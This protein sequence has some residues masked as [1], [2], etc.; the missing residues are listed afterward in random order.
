ML[1][2]MEHSEHSIVSNLPL[3]LQESAVQ[4]QLLYISTP[5][6]MTGFNLVLAIQPSLRLVASGGGDGVIHIWDTET[7]HS[8][9]LEGQRG[10]VT[11]LAFSSD[12]Y[13]LLSGT[14]EDTLRIWNV[15]TRSYT[16]TTWDECLFEANFSPDDHTVALACSDGSV[17]IW[18][19]A[20]RTWHSISR[21]PPRN[22]L[23]SIIS[24]IA[25]SADGKFIASGAWS[26]RVCIWDVEN[27]TSRSF[28]AH[29]EFVEC[30]AWSP[31]GRYLASGS[32]YGSIRI[33]TLETGE[34]SDLRGHEGNISSLSFSPR[35]RHI[36]SGSIDCTVRI[37]DTSNGASVCAPLMGHPGTTKLVTW[38]RDGRFIVSACSEGR[39]RTWNIW[40]ELQAL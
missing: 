16:H 28:A 8:W 13:E 21:D 4:S 5:A 15:E 38:S 40:A 3:L 9:Q 1:C 37:W 11:C 34:Y 2:N 19:I 18:D 30:L 24:C 25:Y 12:G 26:G 33:W 35:G 17:R 7:G 14:I 39:M 22:D 31:D 23:Y 10:Y 36:A 32:K 20:L 29:P 6:P 27:S